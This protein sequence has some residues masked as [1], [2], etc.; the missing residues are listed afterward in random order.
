MAERPPSNILTR[1]PHVT[2]FVRTPLPGTE[3]VRRCGIRTSAVAQSSPW[4]DSM[5]CCRCLTCRCSRGWTSYMIRRYLPEWGWCL[6]VTYEI[7]GNRNARMRDQFEDSPVRGYL[8]ASLLAG[9]TIL[10]HC[11]WSMEAGG[12][13]D[14]ALESWLSRN[15]LY[16]HKYKVQDYLCEVQDHC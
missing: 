15:A 13:C 3:S 2:A 11:S 5:V 9:Q 6:A 12:R 7:F 14:A 4:P 8:T 10:L 1:N 16:L